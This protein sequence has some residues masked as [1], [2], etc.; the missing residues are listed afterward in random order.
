M[1]KKLAFAVA[2]SLMAT[3]SAKA[4]CSYQNEVPLK[5]LSAGFEAWKAVTGAMA[6]CGN[7]KPELDQDFGQKQPAAFA[8]K[9]SLYQIGG[10]ATESIVPLL[11]ARGLFRGDYQGDTLRDHLGLGHFESCYAA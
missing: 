5:S 10:V 8:A 4:A 1:L 7:F 6:E 9:P 2:L 11:Q 3:V